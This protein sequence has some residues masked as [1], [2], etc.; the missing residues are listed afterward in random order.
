MRRPRLI[1]IAL[2]AA[3]GAAVAL[4]APGTA[5][6]AG[7]TAPRSP[8]YVERDAQNIADAYGRQTAPDGQLN[9]AYGLANAQVV[10][11]AYEAQ[12]LAQAATP[13]RPALDTGV[14][15]PAWNAG[16]PYR[17]SWDGSR[18]H[19]PPVAF[20]DRYGA[21]LRGDVFTPKA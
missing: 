10:G 18:G 13:T 3:V 15:V 11:P 20:T 2:A 5:A 7:G 19:I 12:L 14:R 8:Q 16:D 4:T 17:A 9:P 21:L 6:A 1:G